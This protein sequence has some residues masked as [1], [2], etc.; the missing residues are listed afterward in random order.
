L[1]VDPQDYPSEQQRA[2]ETARRWLART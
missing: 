2:L 1:R